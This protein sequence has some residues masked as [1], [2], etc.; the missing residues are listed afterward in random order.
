MMYFELA[1]ELVIIVH[2]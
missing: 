1:F 2:V